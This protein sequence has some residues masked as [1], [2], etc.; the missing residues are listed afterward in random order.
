MDPTKD[1]D[2]D[3]LKT[4]R[5]YREPHL[6]FNQTIVLIV[7]LTVI[8]GLLVN[9]FDKIHYSNLLSQ[10]DGQAGLAQEE[11]GK[12][13]YDVKFLINNNNLPINCFDLRSDFTRSLCATHNS[14]IKNP[15]P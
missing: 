14:S 3:K 12:E 8:T 10:A 7:V 6:S 13:Q 9:F 15:A 1:T 2:P 4:P 11:L 5:F